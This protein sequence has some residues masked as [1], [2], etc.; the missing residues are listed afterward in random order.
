MAKI[1]DFSAGN[2]FPEAEYVEL[3]TIMGKALTVKNV[4]PFENKKGPGV[5]ILAELDGDII[6]ICTHAGA[7]TDTLSRPELIEAAQTEGIGLKFVKKIGKESGKSYIGM[8][9]A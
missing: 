2:P 1:S 5:H 9:D 4:E 3:E 7:V 8:E 6:R